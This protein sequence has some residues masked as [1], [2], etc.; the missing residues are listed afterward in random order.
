MVVGMRGSVLALAATMV[1][2]A[3]VACGGDDEGDSG[4]GNSA[5][6]NGEFVPGDAP[7]MPPLPPGAGTQPPPPPPD[8]PDPPQDAGMNDSGSTPTDSGAQDAPAG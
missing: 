8:D 2:A 6:T 4:N 1:L 3:F 5:Q 7:P